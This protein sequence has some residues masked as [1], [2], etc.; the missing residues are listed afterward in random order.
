MFDE[1]CVFKAFLQKTSISKCSKSTFACC[2]WF[3][4]SWEL[5]NFWNVWSTSYLASLISMGTSI[6]AFTS[7]RGIFDKVYTSS[8]G[9]IIITPLHSLLASHPIMQFTVSKF[10]SPRRVINFSLNGY[11]KQINVH[12]CY[13]YVDQ[14]FWF[15]YIFKEN[16]YQMNI[17]FESS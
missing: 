8:S 14:V 1:V 10:S 4:D 15:E 9:S 11:L 3:L 16:Y 12:V 5:F 7:F 2:S 17:S 13:G 6:R